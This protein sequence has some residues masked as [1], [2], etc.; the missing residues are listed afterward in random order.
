MTKKQTL[1][2]L[3]TL[4]SALV[5]IFLIS[6]AVSYNKALRLRNETNEN[7]A[8]IAVAIEAKYGWTSYYY[9]R[10]YLLKFYSDFIAYLD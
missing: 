1:L 9:K 6:I 5:L 10:Q 8:L 4:V 2:V 3:I 7:K